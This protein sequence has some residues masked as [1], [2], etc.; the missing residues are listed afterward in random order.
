[1]AIC[2]RQFIGREPYCSVC[3]RKPDEVCPL[4]EQHN[5]VRHLRV[6]F[7]YLEDNSFRPAPR[8]PGAETNNGSFYRRQH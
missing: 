3:A 7:C 1:M 8:G 4:Y 6:P 5:T 2:P